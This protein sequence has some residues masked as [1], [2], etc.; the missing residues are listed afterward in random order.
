[1][2]GPAL[3]SP[4]ASWVI[5]LRASAGRGR[6]SGE[7]VTARPPPPILYLGEPPAGIGVGENRRAGGPAGQRAGAGRLAGPATLLRVAQWVMLLALIAA[8]AA[9]WWQECAG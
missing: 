2:P 5:D 3:A 8:A 7:P 9:L 4:S 6:A 1:M